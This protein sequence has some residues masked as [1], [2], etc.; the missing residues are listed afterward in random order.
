[1]STLVALITFGIFV[2]AQVTFT[3]HESIGQESFTSIAIL[4]LDDFLSCLTFCS[5]CVENIVSDFF[6]LF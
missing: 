1:M 5:E 6:M 4:L 3:F 2:A